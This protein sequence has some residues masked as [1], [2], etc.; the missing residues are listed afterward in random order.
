MSK[1]FS[2]GDIGQHPP[3]T[4]LGGKDNIN[5]SGVGR[6][7]ASPLSNLRRLSIP[8]TNTI[9]RCSKASP[10]LSGHTVAMIALI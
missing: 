2:A 7:A 4:E 8:V 6:K 3:D 9:C 10:R 5:I 1:E